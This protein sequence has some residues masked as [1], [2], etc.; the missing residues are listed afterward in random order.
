MNI[1]LVGNGFDL[2]HHFPTN[3][4]DFLNTVQ[5]L[6]K[7]YD[8]SLDTIGKILGNP[9]LKD[10]NGFINKCYEKHAPIY[11][12]T[13]LPQTTAEAIVANAKENPWFNYLCQC[14]SK[15]IY[16]I[17]FEKE[18]LRVLDAFSA[19]FD[20]GSELSL[21][22]N[23]VVFDFASFPT[24]PEDRH[25]LS[26]FN[27]FFEELESSRIGRSRMMRIKSNYAIERVVGS[28]SYHLAIDD[29]VSDLYRSLR[30]LANILRLY[31]LSFVDAPAKEY[32]K[33]DVKPHWASLPAPN[34]VF[35]FN[36]TSTLEIL[37]SNNMVDHIHGSTNTNIVL[38]VNPDETDELGN[39]DTT[40]LQFKKYFQR[41]FFKTDLSFIN[42]I[43]A[44]QA[45]P[46]AN[47]TT[48]Y[49]LGHSLD[50]TDEDI[51]KQIFDVAKS[52][53]ILYHSETSVKN[54]IKNLVQI[55][56]KSGLD[57]LR[58]QK[59]LQFLPQSE[60]NWVFPQ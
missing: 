30:D 59:K 31:L 7:H 1:F 21:T 22:N 34:Y 60:I 38:G 12:A 4:I 49:V 46:R 43:R 44:T 24:N 32:A 47:D 18:I 5:F 35:S 10:H 2:H 6:I 23:H 11:D 20:Y 19:F 52:I 56:G 27:Y 57:T 29:I 3:Y 17:D 9:E 58:E 41:V 25:I 54:Q 39:T 37:H 55:Y 26:Q 42:K 33:L 15:D 50:S 28:G 8:D 14:V 36:Y 16:W 13:P 53:I 51:I 40:F 48:L 45:T